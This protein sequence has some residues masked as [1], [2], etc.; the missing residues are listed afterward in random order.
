MV[1]KAHR[2]LH[3]VAKNRDRSEVKEIVIDLPRR[4]KKEETNPLGIF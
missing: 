2:V 1:V 4:A 3:Q